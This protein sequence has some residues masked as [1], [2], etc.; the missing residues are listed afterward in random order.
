MYKVEL[1]GINIVAVEP[2]FQVLLDMSTLNA[3]LAETVY[4]QDALSI[5]DFYD[6]SA[7]DLRK[8]GDEVF[9]NVSISLQSS[10][11]F[12]PNTLYTINPLTSDRVKRIIFKGLGATATG[13]RQ[14]Q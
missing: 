6:V 8:R 10:A 3:Y 7:F 13:D 9:L 14:P 11:Q 2:L 12:D 5:A 1:D 4:D